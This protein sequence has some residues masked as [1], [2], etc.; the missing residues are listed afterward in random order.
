MKRGAKKIGT[1][2]YLGE[3][4]LEPWPKKGSR[5]GAHAAG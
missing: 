2:L 1:R 4:T 5:E 3:K